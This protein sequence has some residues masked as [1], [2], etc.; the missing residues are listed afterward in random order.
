MTKEVADALPEE[1]RAALRAFDIL[2]G[3]VIT[4]ADGKS[5]PSNIQST[6]DAAQKRR[7]GDLNVQKYYYS[8]TPD[9]HFTENHACVP[10]N[11]GK[12][13]PVGLLVFLL[14]LV[15]FTQQASSYPRGASGNCLR[16][17]AR[18]GGHSAHRIR[19]DADS[20]DSVRHDS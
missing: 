14:L 4:F 15:A 12:S 2:G 5:V 1:S 16:P 6:A 17:D 3:A 13:L 18:R 10:I 11:V 8:G 19:H 7:I 20:A 9:S